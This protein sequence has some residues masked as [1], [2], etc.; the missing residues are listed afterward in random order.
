M[1]CAPGTAYDTKD[2]ECTVRAKYTATK[3]QTVKPSKIA[4]HQDNFLFTFLDH[5]IFNKN[6][7]TTKFLFSQVAKQKVKLNFTEG[8]EDERDK[9]PVYVVNNNVTF[10]QGVAK[11]DGTSRLRVPQLSN[12]DYG[13]AVV[14]KIK[15]RETRDT[16]NKAQA[17]ISNGDCG[18]NASILVAKD[19]EKITFGAETVGGEYTQVEIPKPKTEWKTVKYAYND[20]RLQGTVNGHSKSAWIPSGGRIQ[21]RPCALQIGHGEGLGDFQGDI[22]DVSFI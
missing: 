18:N 20:G 2:C 15:F 7:K 19:A 22:E 14:L 5:N 10:G 16:S 11:F 4:K 8:F 6:E 21:A 12:V 3:E 9:R 13:E 1:P 17:I